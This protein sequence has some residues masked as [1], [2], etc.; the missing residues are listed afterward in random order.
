MSSVSWMNRALMAAY[1]LIE[2]LA[3]S[4]YAEEKGSRDTFS[5]VME[6]NDNETIAA[7]QLY[8]D[9]GQKMAAERELLV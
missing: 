9:E 1:E 3:D 6:P 4:G 8:V 5:P 2:T 7:S